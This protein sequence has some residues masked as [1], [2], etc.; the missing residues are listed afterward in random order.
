MCKWHQNVFLYL[1]SLL[2]WLHRPRF[3]GSLVSLLSSLNSLKIKLRITLS[4]KADLLLVYRISINSIYV[5]PLK[6]RSQSLGVILFVSFFLNPAPHPS[7]ATHRTCCPLLLSPSWFKP[8]ASPTWTI[9]TASKL[10]SL[11]PP[12][13]RSVPH[14]TAKSFQ[15]A[16][17]ILLYLCLQFFKRF[18]FVMLYEHISKSFYISP[19]VI[20]YFSPFAFLALS[21][22]S[23]F[24]FHT[25]PKALLTWGLCTG[26]SLV[27]EHSTTQS[28][29]RKPV[30]HSKE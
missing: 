3:R 11:H 9:P 2:C 10:V 27:L 24:Q 25:H 17:V 28:P 23:T 4:P 20:L 26:C 18:F 15:Y 30:A 6:N 22:S 13:A 12:H 19:P 7:S 8:L 14:K 21:T 5:L 29:G 1:R 16:S